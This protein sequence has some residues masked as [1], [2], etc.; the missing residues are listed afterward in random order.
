MARPLSL[1]THPAVWACACEK[2]EFIAPPAF[3]ATPALPARGSFGSNTDRPLRRARGG[4][5]VA[6]KPARQWPA[7][8]TR[9]APATALPGVPAHVKGLA[10][11]IGRRLAGFVILQA[12][13]AVH[14]RHLPRGQSRR[15]PTRAGGE[16]S[17]VDFDSRVAAHPERS[18]PGPQT[19]RFRLRPAC[20][21]SARV[22]LPPSASNA[23]PRGRDREARGPKWRGGRGWRAAAK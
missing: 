7:G 21:C 2:I 10:V 8:S 18:G 9:D 23:K 13:K 5:D 17:R 14:V 12:A 3:I 1:R 15:A 4:S 16:A 22:F 6:Q 20:G 11:V 19:A